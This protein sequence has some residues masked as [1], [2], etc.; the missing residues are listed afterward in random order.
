MEIIISVLERKEFGFVDMISARLSLVTRGN[1]SLISK[2]IYIGKI[3]EDDL[4]I[5]SDYFI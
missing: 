5:V 2:T 1:W 4:S 3:T